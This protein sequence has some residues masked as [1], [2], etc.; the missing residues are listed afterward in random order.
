MPHPAQPIRQH[1]PLA[2]P[3]GTQHG[4][5]PL[6]SAA[7]SRLAEAQALAAQPYPGNL[8]A[9]AG[10]SVARLGLALAPHARQVW[11]LCGP[12]N[13]GG[14]GLVA[15]RLL[16]SAG[17]QVQVAL[18]GADKRRPADAEQALQ[19]A[20]AAGVSMR[21]QLPTAAHLRG[22]D[23]V[24][25]ALLGLGAASPPGAP[26]RLASADMAQAINAINPAGQQ[27]HT[28]VLAVDLPSGLHA[29]TG[30]A[31]HAGAPTSAVRA[32]AT[33]SLLTL[34]PGCFTGQGREHAGAVWFDDLSAQHAVPATAWLGL[35]TP[36]QQQTQAHRVGGRNNPSGHKGLFGDVA[37]VAGS[38][39]MV[40]A[41]WLASRAALAAGAGRV[42]CSLLTP[43][44]DA[45][46]GDLQQP[47]IMLRHQ[48]WLGP[49]DLLLR[50][51]VVC[52]CGGGDA[53][54]AALPRLLA[55]AGRLVLDADALNAVATSPQLA[56][57]LA[58]RAARGLPTVLTPHPLEAA[59]LLGA[60]TAA[61]QADRLAAANALALRYQ[62]TVVLKGSG[63]VV[64]SPG[65]LPSI[66]SSGNA[67]LATAGTG[68]V[69]AGWLGGL[70]AQAGV[71]T[72]KGTD[73][74]GDTGGTTPAALAAWQH[75]HA[76]DRF[77]AAG[78][79]A[80]QTRSEQGAPLLASQL[81]QLLM[82]TA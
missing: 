71:G 5:W 47:E 13:N 24:I 23:Q 8:M 29:D 79:L 53:V 73:A 35:P 12:G 4:P 67:A 59:R 63:T 14:D 69:L 1:S 37:V 3:L 31:S 45:L 27:P 56:Q 70:W 51:T 68:D 50:T 60:T 46:L 82:T 21:A 25:D 30:C 41:A 43:Q 64:A 7:A 16:H 80:G 34:K 26:P 2:L 11:V 48:W 6:H 57:Q 62:A 32:H 58:A 77:V 74:G 54:A 19:Q 39:G 81:I 65:C 72:G 75:G 40:G 20:Q 22:A 36:A 10:Q 18:V 76:A 28:T 42:F 9:R 55:H 49:E 33:L 66:N 78:K 44:N 15:A 52:G 17:L 61:V 38:S